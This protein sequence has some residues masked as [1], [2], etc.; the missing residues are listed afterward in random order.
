[1]KNQTIRYRGFLLNPCSYQLAD[2]KKWIPK[3]VLDNGGLDRTIQTPLV[4]NKKFDTEKEANTYAILQGKMFIDKNSRSQNP[5]LRG[6]KV[7]IAK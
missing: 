5:T 4:W 3:L 2:S 6:K 1:M 7:K